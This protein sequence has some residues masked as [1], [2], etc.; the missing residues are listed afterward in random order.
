LDR[1]VICFVPA[2]NQFD[3][4]CQPKVPAVFEQFDVFYISLIEFQ[5]VFHAERIAHICQEASAP[6]LRIVFHT[7]F[8]SE[9]FLSLSAPTIDG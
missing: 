7:Q 1:I 2:H 5:K 3:F 9:G 8:R 4:G 6:G